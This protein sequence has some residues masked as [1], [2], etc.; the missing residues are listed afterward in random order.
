MKK[1]IDLLRIKHWIKNVLIF[2]P[3]I[4]A[5][6][7]NLDNF[8]VVLIG[9]FSFSFTTS[10][11]YIMNDI[12]DI[13]ID[14]LHPRKKN[15]PIAN[16]EISRKRAII[17]SFIMLLLAFFLSL[18]IYDNYAIYFL[19]GYII[20]NIL[21]SF[22]LKNITIIDIL[23]LASCYIL[24]IY[25]GAALLS[26]EVSDWLFLTIMS[27]S[28]FL[29]FGKR[30]KELLNNIDTREVLKKYNEN[31]LDRFQYLCL[32]L[33]FVFYALW[34]REQ[35]SRYLIYT[36]LLLMIIF[37]KYALI[38]DDNDDGDPITILYSDKSLFFLCILY[39]IVMFVLFMMF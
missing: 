28:F 17:I 11:V 15:R 26:I 32:S 31:F 18:F 7:V 13:N 33:V 3:M 34:A 20:V 25:Y 37:M 1:Y 30:K 38:L 14:K 9:F 4:C 29:G 21:Y 39:G 36:V 8:L 6:E 2:L 19:L 24:R 16:G 12:K 22:G 23:L 5:K 10:F 27:A 35:N